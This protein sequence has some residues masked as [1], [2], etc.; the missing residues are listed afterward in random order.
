MRYLSY[1]FKVL[2]ESFK[3]YFADQ[4]FLHASSLTFYTL[5]SL[6]PG[7]AVVL[8]LAKGF[9]FERNLE[10]ELNQRFEDQ[11][12]LVQLTLSFARK[13]LIQFEGSL[14][15]GVGVI[16]LFLFVM[17]LFWSIENS[18]N[19]IWKVKR[20]RRLIRMITDYF[21]MMIICPFL[22]AIAS[23]SMVYMSS[24]LHSASEGHEVLQKISPYFFIFYRALTLL[25]IWLLITAIYTFMPNKY[26]PLKYAALAG[27]LAAFAYYFVQAIL[28]KFQ[29][30]VSQY[31][32]VY[33]SFAALPIFL[34]WLQIS[35]T[36][37]LLGAEVAY[38]LDHLSPSL[39]MSSQTLLFSRSH[40]AVLLTLRIINRF[41]KG[42]PP[43]GDKE[44]TDEL[45]VPAAITQELLEDLKG[46]GILID[47]RSD[48]I[49]R[50]I[51]PA[52]DIA[53]INL[54]MIHHAIDLNQKTEIRINA[55]KEAS[56]V[57]NAWNDFEAAKEDVAANKT[58]V[59]LTKSLS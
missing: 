52:M 5:L 51:Q 35:W 19:V 28:I 17:S 54:G 8:G 15:T 14:I 37:I 49:R 31:N 26:V 45:G 1:L 30:G 39:H 48:K 43:I 41:Q 59:E 25:M 11:Q 40:L 10:I 18:L 6:V 23:S 58:L 55:S 36:I 57:L 2:R 12:D 24:I 29:I 22:F 3:G 9:G 38:N 56:V 44:L 13:L 53:N 32:A 47:V 33:G 7:L 50:L 16:L 20:S 27:A 21:A 4:C 34:L 46:K 42:E